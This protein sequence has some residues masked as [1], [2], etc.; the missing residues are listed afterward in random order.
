MPDVISY[1]CDM[2]I[3][4]GPVNKRVVGS[5]IFEVIGRY[6]DIHVNDPC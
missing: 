5:G 2:L 4:A 3:N 6:N 1:M